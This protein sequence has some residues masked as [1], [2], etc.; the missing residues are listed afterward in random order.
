M[1]IASTTYVRAKN[2]KEDVNI[3]R[4]NN[5]ERELLIYTGSALLNTRYRVHTGHALRY[6]WYIPGTIFSRVKKEI[7]GFRPKISENLRKKTR[8]CISTTAVI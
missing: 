5:E 3:I 2:S 4:E 6:T 7:R 8:T 1:R